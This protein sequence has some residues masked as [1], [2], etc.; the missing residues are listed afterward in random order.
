M[1]IKDIPSGFYFF[2]MEVGNESVTQKVI[3]K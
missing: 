2:K 3:I 1:E